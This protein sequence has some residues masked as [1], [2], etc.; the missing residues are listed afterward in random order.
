MYF[1]DIL[2]YSRAEKEYIRQVFEVMGTEKKV[3]FI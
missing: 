1:D 2:I 3:L